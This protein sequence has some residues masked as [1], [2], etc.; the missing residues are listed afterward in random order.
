MNKTPAELRSAWMQSGLSRDNLA[1]DPLDQFETWYTQAIDSGIP[2]PNALTL[3]TADAD[4]QPYARTVLLKIYDQQGFVFFTNYGSAK[5]RQLAA[6]ER[7]AMLFPWIALGRQ[8]KIIGSAA[9]ITTAESFK[10]FAS[11]PRGS[12]LGAW[13]SPQSEVIS[14]RSLLDEKFAAM[15]RRFSD[16]DI[17]LPDFWG[18]YRVVAR[19]IEFWQARDD[20]LHDRFVYR[21]DGDAWH[22][23]RQAP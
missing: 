3:A 11:R 12:Q 20:R 1:T 9:R 2:E 8:V 18:G 15:K 5:A 4:G 21:R 23:E 6:N 17:P 22:I 13:A 10:Y 16:G 19:E 14:S 7:V